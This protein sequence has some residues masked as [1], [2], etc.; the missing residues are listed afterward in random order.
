MR[1]YNNLKPAVPPKEITDFKQMLETNSEVYNDRI[2]YI[3]KEDGEMKELTFTEF[4]AKVKAFTTFLYEK[5]LNGKR[6]AIT[7]DTSPYW[8]VAFY[9]AVI[10]G[11]VAV[12]LDRE[13]DPDQMTEFIKIAECSAIVY[14][15]SVADKVEGEIANLP[16]LSN[17]FINKSLYFGNILYIISTN[18]Y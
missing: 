10:S 13:L 9:A 8:M 18:R 16:D 11:G 2:Q 1:T 15:A 14:T 5:G 12:P 6:I 4:G 17:F 3:F 7:G